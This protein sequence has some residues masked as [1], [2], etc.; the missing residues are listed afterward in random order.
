MPINERPF[1]AIRPPAPVAP[2]PRRM[3]LQ[4]WFEYSALKTVDRARMIVAAHSFILSTSD[5]FAKMLKFKKWASDNG[6]RFHPAHMYTP[7]EVIQFAHGTIDGFFE[8]IGFVYN[9]NVQNLE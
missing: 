4:T 6:Y 2:P 5:D 9:G 7:H 8:A 3:S 1:E